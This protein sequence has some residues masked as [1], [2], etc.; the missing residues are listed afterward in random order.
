MSGPEFHCQ[1]VV[2]GLPRGVRTWRVTTGVRGTAVAVA[3]L[4]GGEPLACG[5]GGWEVLTQADEVGV[6]VEGVEERRLTF[7]LVDG[8]GLGVCAFGSGA[9]SLDQVFGA[10]VVQLCGSGEPMRCD[11]GIGTVVVTTGKGAK[12]VFVRPRLRV[13]GRWSAAA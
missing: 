11:L 12:D 6:V 3:G 8:C 7:R 1:R 5:G 9:W 2:R 10:S 4:L 13:V